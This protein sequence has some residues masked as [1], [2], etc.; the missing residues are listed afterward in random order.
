MPRSGFIGGYTK[1]APDDDVISSGLISKKLLLS[2]IEIALAGR[3]AEIVVF[4][5]SEITQYA[6]NNINYST[7]IA[8]EMVTKYGFSVIGPVC[9][10]QKN[11][12]VFLGNSLLRN[13]SLIADKTSSIID[14]QIIKISKEALANAVLKIS[15]NRS[16]LEKIVE[17]LIDEETID[18]NRFKELSTNLLKV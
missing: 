16:M 3:A 4:G 5:I 1:I 2:K 13:K 8:K 12:E 7:D 17:V 6:A 15:K 18:G 11:D 14:N 9:L 10:D